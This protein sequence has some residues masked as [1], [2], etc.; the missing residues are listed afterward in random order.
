MEILDY[1]HYAYTSAAS[2]GD[3]MALAET[4]YSSDSFAEFAEEISENRRLMNVSIL[5][6]VVNYNTN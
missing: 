1:T 3:A 2:I 5:V 6:N 4:M